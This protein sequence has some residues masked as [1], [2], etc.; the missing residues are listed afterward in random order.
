[1]CKNKKI[2]KMVRNKVEYTQQLCKIN[3]VCDKC[4]K[5]VK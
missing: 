4:K 5:D 2:I 3:V 1:M